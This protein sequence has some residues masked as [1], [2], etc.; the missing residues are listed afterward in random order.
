M[1]SIRWAT[2][3]ACAPVTSKVSGDCVAAPDA[4]LDSCE[5]VGR[6]PAGVVDGAAVPVA[7]QAASNT[8]LIVATTTNEPR[9]GGRTIPVCGGRIRLSIRGRIEALA[10]GFERRGPRLGQRRSALDTVAGRVTELEAIGGDRGRLD[11]LRG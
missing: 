11:R 3:V 5:L 4:S 9:S 1:K 6:E 7:V 10:T 8:V 2:S